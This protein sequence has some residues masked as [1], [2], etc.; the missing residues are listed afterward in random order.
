MKTIIKS[1]FILSLLALVFIGCADRTDL[2]DPS[3]ATVS[4]GTAN[5]ARFVSIGN[6]ITAGYQ[7]SSLFEDAQKYSFGAQLAKQVHTG[8]VEP[9][10]SNPG[11]GGRID[12]QSVDVTKGSVSFYYNA[13]QGGSP[14]NTSY[15]APY[16]NLGI[17]GAILYDVLDT[18]D[19][20]AKSTSRAN[21]YFPLVLRSAALG[22][23]I[24]AQAKALKPT[25]MTLWIGNNDVLGYATS[26]GTS[27][28]MTGTKTPTPTAVFAGLYAQLI[29]TIKADPSFASTKIAVGNIPDVSSIPFFTT[30]GPKVAPA[31]TAALMAKGLDATTAASTQAFVYQKHEGGTIGTASAND[32]SSGTVLLTLPGMNYAPYIG[33][34]TGKFWWD[35]GYNPANIG[36]DTTKPFGFSATNPFPDALVVDAAELA[37][38]VSAVA[39]FNS[40]ISSLVSSEANFVLVDVNASMK[41]IRNSDIAGT[42]YDG[43]TF[44]ST[45][46]TG[47]LFSLDGVHPSN[48]GHA[49]IGNVFIS[50]INA[51]FGASIPAINVSTVPTGLNYRKVMPI[52]GDYNFFEFAPHTFHNLLF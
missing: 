10:V 45:F 48:Q 52:K 15:G 39:S 11:I 51:K 43:I 9:L 12:I 7:S 49:V 8:Y 50:A 35:N 2:V 47:G 46:L 40:T 30:V 24:L 1:G 4:T 32:L 20:A 25:F 6:S 13:K 38:I 27:L 3:T 16:N 19:F 29:G 36:I 26:G 22:K 37:L 17:P 31:V 28:S 41:A 42:V 44:R 33:T 21:P 5:F 14:L 18:T 34:A 23:S